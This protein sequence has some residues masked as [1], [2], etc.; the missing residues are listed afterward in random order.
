MPRDPTP[1]LT[2][3][4]FLYRRTKTA[5]VVNRLPA[6]EG[7]EAH[8]VGVGVGVGHETEA[9]A[10]VIHEVELD[11]SPA[12][13]ELLAALR[14]PERDRVTPLDDTGIH[15]E[16][17]LADR[18][19]EPELAP[20]VADRDVVEEHPAHT[21]RLVAVGQEEVAIAPVAVLGIG[22]R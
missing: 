13:C 5:C 14:F 2:S 15:V 4:Q 18:F 8:E 19:L 21:A 22:A 11:V 20:P 1:Q 16:K 17:R 7:R 10:A 12:L 9:G 3:C 6:G